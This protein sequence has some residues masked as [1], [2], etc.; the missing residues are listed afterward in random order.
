MKREKE[1][2]AAD[3]IVVVRPSTS[4]GGSTPAVPSVCPSTSGGGSTPAVPSVCPNIRDT[5]AKCQNTIEVASHKN[6]CDN[7]EALLVQFDQKTKGAINTVLLL[8]SLLH[9]QVWMS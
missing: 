3:K 6:V 7:D 4:G 5:A 8:K 2:F 9:R 1:Q